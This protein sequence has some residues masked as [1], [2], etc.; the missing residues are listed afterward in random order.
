VS[1]SL[2]TRFYG[3][4]NAQ[5]DIWIALCLRKAGEV[6]E[7][8]TKAEDRL[9]IVVQTDVYSM[10]DLSRLP[11]YKDAPFCADPEKALRALTVGIS[12]QPFAQ[13]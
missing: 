6:R 9:A 12:Q 7:F 1:A 5:G 8:A 3:Y 11:R 2:P 13:K 10:C 4:S